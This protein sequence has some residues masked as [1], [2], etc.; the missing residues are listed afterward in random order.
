VTL[1][2]VNEAPVWTAGN[3]ASSEGELT[4]LPAR[5]DVAVVGAGYTGLAAALALCKRGVS[6]AVLESERVGFGASSRNGG[7]AL[8]GLKLSPEV[9]LRRYGAATARALFAA[10]LEAI[11]LVESLVASEGIECAFQRCGHLEL[12]SKAA[13]FRAF[14][15]TAASLSEVFGHGVELLGRSELAAE[16]GSPAF[17]GAILDARSAGIDPWRYAGGLAHAARRAGAAVCERA[18][19]E[20]VE[21]RHGE[22]KVKSSRG[23]VNARNVLLATGAYTGKVFPALQRR[24]VP[25][26]SYAIATEPLPDALAASLLP[27]NRVAFDSKRLLH[28]F[29]LTPDRRMLF[30]GR[31]A[32]VPE[33]RRTVSIAAAMLRADM[34]AFFPQL[35]GTKVEY[36]WGGT[37]DVTFDVMPHLGTAGG[38]H[39]A[40]GYAGHGVALATLLGTLAAAAI[41]GDAASHPFASDAPPAPLLLYDGRPWFLPVVG[42]WQRLLD[43]VS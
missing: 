29:R 13:H 41:A 20:T 38:M 39:Y 8:T 37:L 5:V 25:I 17:Y 28:Y 27:R 26:G 2:G 15:R 12:A 31:A 3:A 7:M 4:A 34:I 10:S 18:A 36:A 24:F 33:S 16:I 43:A 40:V 14:G 30:G 19:V 11:G 23:E 21:Q 22:W 9:L 6:V 42:A 1:D 32:F 35:T